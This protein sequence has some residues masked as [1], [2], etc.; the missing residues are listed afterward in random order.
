MYSFNT[1]LIRYMQAVVWVVDAEKSICR[2][3]DLK[4]SGSEIKV[5]GN[6]ILN[7]EVT[8]KPVVSLVQPIPY[9]VS[10]TT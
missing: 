7:I 10:V 1:A 6:H 9:V 3:H 8:G 2:L 4:K 5:G